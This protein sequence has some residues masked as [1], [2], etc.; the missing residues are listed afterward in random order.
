[1]YDPFTADDATEQVRELAEHIIRV[2]MKI[3]SHRLEA[4]TI[5]I[6]AASLAFQS[7][8]F[9]QD[10]VINLYSSIFLKLLVVPV[11][12]KESYPHNFL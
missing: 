6:A 11:T 5:G 3:T 2:V 8:H 12:V 10:P 4:N 1:M 7:C 9:S